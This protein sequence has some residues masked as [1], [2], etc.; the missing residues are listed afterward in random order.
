MQRTCTR[1]NLIRGQNFIGGRD[2]IGGI[3]IWRMFAVL[4]PTATWQYGVC[5][6]FSRV[7][8]RVL[9][10]VYFVAADNV[11]VNSE[12]FAL[13]VRKMYVCHDEGDNSKC[14]RLQTLFYVIRTAEKKF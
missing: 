7:R 2:F 9:G 13:S 10:A 12:V 4:R 11:D 14:Y 6:A 5:L 1:R 8:R 3:R